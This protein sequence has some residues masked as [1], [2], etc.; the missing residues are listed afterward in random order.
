[1]AKRIIVTLDTTTTPPTLEVDIRELKID[2]NSKHKIIWEID[3]NLNLRFVPMTAK[4]PGFSW[5]LPP[6]P[7]EGVFGPP[8]ISKNDPKYLSIDDDNA[9]EN[10]SGEWYYGLRAED[11]NGKVYA[12][13]GILPIAVPKTPI[14]IN[15]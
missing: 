6:T 4:E 3:K 15:Q 9:K 7:P 10:S 2:K 14:I 11:M 8:E 13:I 1:M 5:L 12:T